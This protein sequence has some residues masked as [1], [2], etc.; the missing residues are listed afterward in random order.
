MIAFQQVSKFQSKRFLFKDANFQINPGERV[1]L[2][3]HNGAG[4]ST[5]FRMIVGEESADEGSITIPERFTVGYFSQNPAAE[6]HLT[7]LECAMAGAWEV[8]TLGQRIEELSNRLSDPELADMDA[9][10]EE[11]GEA[12]SVFETLGGYDLEQRAQEILSGLGFSAADQERKVGEFSGGWRMRIELARV[13]L[14]KP[15]ALLMDEPTNHLDVE[16]IIWLEEFLDR[17][18]GAIFMTSHDRDFMNRLVSKIVAV[19]HGGITV[20][21]GNYDFYVNESATRLANLEAAAKRQEKALEKEEE[22]IARFKARASHAAQVQSRVKMIEKMDR[23]EVPKE[24]RAVDF[25]WP[26]CPRSGD[27]VATISGVGKAYGEKTVL[28][29]I[30]LQIKRLDRVAFLGVNG[31]GKSTLLKILAQQLSPDQGE[32]KLGASLSVGYFAQHQTE[33]LKPDMTVY[34]AV[35]EVA[36]TTSRASIQNILGSLLFSGDDVEKQISV[37]SGGE[38][39]RLVLARIIANP[40]NFLILDEPTNHLDIRTRE[41]LLEAL[42]Q[43]E[44]TLVFVSHDRHFLRDV[45]TKVILIDQGHTTEYLGGLPDFLEKNGNRFPGSQYQQTLRVG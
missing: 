37:L 21:S 8:H 14:R 36:P 35:Q 17:Y 13:L 43:F 40:C 24:L 41:V 15:D 19:E 18:P 4:K 3:G 23:I 30:D 12:Q 20:Y 7:V 38:K 16:T 44:G 28:E 31:A 39:T 2:V 11:L 5:L 34:E 9:V 25:Q 26:A 6:V 45:A 27:I 32:C 10:L 1:G 33:I 29:N 22:F 42:Q